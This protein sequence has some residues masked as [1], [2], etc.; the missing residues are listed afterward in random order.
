M[1][2]PVLALRDVTLWYREAPIRRFVNYL[3]RHP[4][5][6]SPTLHGISLDLSAGQVLAVIGPSG[7]GKSTLCHGFLGEISASGQIRLASVV[8]LTIAGQQASNL[9][10]FVPQQP[11]LY[12]EL[13][14]REALLQVAEI[15]LSSDTSV[16]E[17]T[18]R[19]D[20]TIAQVGLVS[21]A[22]R[23]INKLSG[24][25]LK[26]ASVAMELLSD[27]VLLVLD[28]PT[29]GLDEGLDRQI[30]DLLKEVASRGCAVVVVTHSLA[31][32]DRVNT[33]LALTADGRPG[34]CG[35]PQQLLAAFSADNYATVMN[36]LRSGVT[37]SLPQVAPTAPVVASDEAE[38][39]LNGESIQRH[40]LP[41]LRREFARQLS[42]PK[43]FLTSAVAF[44]LLA[45]LICASASP[46]GF[47]ISETNPYYKA[48]TV[49]LVLTICLTFF[50]TAQTFSSIVGD[51][52]VIRREFRWGVSAG[53]VIL[54]RAVAFAPLSLWIGASSTLL[55]WAIRPSPRA[56]LL[57][58]I[59][60]LLLFAALTS[61][62][63]MALGLL[64]STVSTSLRQATFVLMGVLA[65]QVV[66]TGIALPLAAGSALSWISFVAMSRWSVAGFGS[67]INIDCVDRHLTRPCGPDVVPDAMWRS[68]MAHLWTAALVLIG[69]SV[70]TIWVAKL[71]LASQLKA[72]L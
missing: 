10:S 52:A 40:F 2:T 39:S 31:N 26:R 57:Y 19:V 59:S 72:R 54:T 3:L 23:P 15:R 14:V 8:D 50:T 64:I 67:D 49:L 9:V 41:L 58:G 66:L 61:M 6:V 55:M 38:T 65:A 43:T 27:P 22:D 33:V 25:Q 60:G 28:E 24:G 56:P 53:S 68:D 42:T 34:Y 4:A 1:R 11:D 29:S 48:R 16:A 51:R 18:Q 62:A 70:L 35:E 12:P 17:R 69:L 71:R 7:A 13:G 21:V 30:M 32:V 45:F 63:G 20:A 5:K 36:Q 47:R 46:F 44:P 37:T